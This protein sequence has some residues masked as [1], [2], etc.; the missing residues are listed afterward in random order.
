MEG[1]CSQRG[2]ASWTRTVQPCL[3]PMTIESHRQRAVAE[4]CARLRQLLGQELNGFLL[5]GSEARGDAMEGSDIDFLVIMRDPF[6]YGELLERTSELTA[7]ISLE[8]D[9]VLARAFF[10]RRDMEFSQA[11]FLMAVRREGIPL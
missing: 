7:E 3:M 4:Y 5:Y 1:A 6:D 2:R 10:T 9:V 11:P 8:H